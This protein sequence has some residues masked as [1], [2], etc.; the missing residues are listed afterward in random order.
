MLAAD[1]VESFTRAAMLCR[2]GR[3]SDAE[4][5]ASTEQKKKRGAAK[6]VAASS[7]LAALEIYDSMESAALLVLKSS[8][9]ASSGFIGHRYITSL[10]T[11]QL[12]C[13]LHLSCACCDLRCGSGEEGAS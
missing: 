4:A 8:G 3:T 1:S 6:N 9:D 10:A 12:N 2:F 7:V 5:L 13:H 11:G